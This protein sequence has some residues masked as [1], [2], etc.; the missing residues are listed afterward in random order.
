MNIIKYI[1]L[2]ITEGVSS[3]KNASNRQYDI[4]TEGVRKMREDLFTEGQTFATDKTS[5]KKDWKNV[6]GDM[7]AAYNKYLASHE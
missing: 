3:L 1:I 7:R 6:F 5:L 4:Q 2:F